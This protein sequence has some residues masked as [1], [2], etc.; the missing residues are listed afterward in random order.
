MRYS[1]LLSGL[2]ELSRGGRWRT[3]TGDDA[4]VD[5]VS[6]WVERDSLCG[7]PRVGKKETYFQ[8]S[9]LNMI[10]R[11]DTENGQRNAQRTQAGSNGRGQ[12]IEAPLVEVDKIRD[13]NGRHGCN[14]N[15]LELPES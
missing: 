15:E 13:S 9:G 11:A 6:C 14:E 7:F 5:Q 8:K 4:V 10:E 2:G 12:T 1:V 3:L